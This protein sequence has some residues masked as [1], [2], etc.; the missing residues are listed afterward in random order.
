[1]IHYIDHFKAIKKVRKKLKL[2]GQGV[3]LVFSREG[4]PNISIVMESEN[5]NETLQNMNNCKVT[6]GHFTSCTQ[7]R[8]K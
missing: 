3:P 5:E 8:M 7:L 2:F 6:Q 4:F 1:M